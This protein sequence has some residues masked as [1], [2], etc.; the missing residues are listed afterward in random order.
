VASKLRDAKD[1]VAHH[2]RSGMK[3]DV[4]KNTDSYKLVIA[5]EP[6]FQL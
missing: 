2:K 5:S 3:P 4:I 6:N 1:I